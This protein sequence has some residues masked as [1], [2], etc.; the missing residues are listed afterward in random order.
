MSVPEEKL[1]EFVD[2]MVVRG[3]GLYG[4]EA[5]AQICYDSGIALTDKHEIEWLDANHP[6]AVQKL[7]INYGSRN[8]PAKMTSIVLARKYNIPVPEKLLAKK[9][10]KRRFIFSRNR[11]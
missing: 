2:M 7:L 9:K 8:I 1:K 5:I 4:T 6:M 10:V 11:K 3:L